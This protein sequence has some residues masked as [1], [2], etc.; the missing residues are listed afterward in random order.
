MLYRFVIRFHFV[1][2]RRCYRQC[3]QEGRA[4][5]WRTFESD[6]AVVV[7]HDILDDTQPK[8]HTT[9]LCGELWLKNTV[10]VLYRD[11]FAV[12]FYRNFR[13]VALTE[14][15]HLHRWVQLLSRQGLYGI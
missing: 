6:A 10:F 7:L 11:A 2:F 13:H 12:V 4:A 5:S 1:S 8:A 14:Y 15:A 3:N 9:A